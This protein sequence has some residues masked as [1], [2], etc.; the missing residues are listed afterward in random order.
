MKWIFTSTLL[1]A[2]VKIH[3][4]PVFQMD[5]SGNWS[6]H[7]QLTVISQS[8]SGFSAAYSGKNSLDNA[9]ETG[10]T[11]LT[12]TLFLGRKLWKGAAAY[13]NPEMSGGNGLSYSQGV[14]GALNGETYRVGNVAPQL[15]IARAYLQQNIALGNSKYTNVADDENQVT[16]KVPNNR[17]TI[18]AGKFAISD[19]YDDN[20]YSHDPRTQFFNWSLMGNGAWDYPANTRGYTYGIVA[21]WY[22]NNWS[23]RLSS[24]AVPTIANSHKM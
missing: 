13:F 2:C 24:V 15:F 6:H 8:H 5:S 18:T 11:S 9:V 17:I 4:Q 21:E 20:T 16:D 10:A 14:A 19:F 1:F 7:F 3:A 23:F 12:T 22:Q